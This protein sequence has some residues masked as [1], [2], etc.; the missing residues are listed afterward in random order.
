ME[1]KKI[2]KKLLI[3]IAI[4]LIVF[5]AIFTALYYMGS[6]K[7][8]YSDDQ[9]EAVE[10]LGKPDSFVITFPKDENGNIDRYEEWHFHK[11]GVMAGFYNGEST[12]F[13]EIDYLPENTV[14]ASYEPGQFDRDM[15]WADLKQ[16]LTDKVWDKAS[17]Y[18]PELFSGTDVDLY[19]SDQI[20]VG[21]ENSTNNVV[22]IETMVLMPEEQK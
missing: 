9:M 4:V 11:Y 8:G 7:Y 20:V 16:K 22:Y 10:E 6:S 12:L 19:Y 14:P 1:I 15:K 2:F 18:L 17:D 21:I 13:D 5:A 3:S